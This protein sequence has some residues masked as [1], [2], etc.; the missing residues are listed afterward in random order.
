MARADE[1]ISAQLLLGT[2]SSFKGCVFL[3]VV[4]KPE[5]GSDRHEVQH[6]GKTLDEHTAQIK[7]FWL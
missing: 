6:P 7:I 5:C 3:A 1:S 2:S 4:P